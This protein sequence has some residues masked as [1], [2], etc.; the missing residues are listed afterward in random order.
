[1]KYLL[2]ENHELKTYNDFIKKDPLLMNHLSSYKYDI[3]Y[4][5]TRLNIRSIRDESTSVFNDIF[6]RDQ[7]KYDLFS[8][9]T[10]QQ[11]HF[12]IIS[13]INNKLKNHDEIIKN[14]E[15]ILLIYKGGNV[16][17]YYIN[18]KIAELHENLIKGIKNDMKFNKTS[19][20]DYTIYIVNDSEKKFNLIYYYVGEL[21]YNSLK[22]ISNFFNNLLNN[23]LIDNENENITNKNNNLFNKDNYYLIENNSDLGIQFIHDIYS[24]ISELLENSNITSLEDYISIFTSG[25]KILLFNN[26]YTGTRYIKVLQLLKYYNNKIDNLR[27][28]NSDFFDSIDK[29]INNQNKL[30]QD[31][32]NKLLFR[33][34]DFYRKDKLQELINKITTSMNSKES[35]FGKKLYDYKNC[36]RPINYYKI[37]NEYDYYNISQKNNNKNNIITLNPR[38]NTLLKNFN[39]I[40][41]NKLIM[42]SPKENIPNYHY[43]SINS[44]INNYI[45][46]SHIVNFDLFRIKLNLKLPNISYLNE[47]NNYEYNSDSINNNNIETYKEDEK[48]KKI[49][50]PTLKR[51][52]S[53]VVNQKKESTCYAHV[54]CRCIVKLII[55]YLKEK[56]ESNI[57][58]NEQIYFES[59]K[60]FNRKIKNINK[61]ENI[62]KYN[63]NILYYYI[64][65]LIKKKNGCISRG[66]HEDKELEYLINYIMKK[67]YKKSENL[68]I[69]HDQKIIK[70]INNIFDLFREKIID[71]KI[72]FNIKNIKYENILP[73]EIKKTLND[74]LY[75]C[76]CF[77]G[78]DNFWKK[79]KSY[80]GEDNYDFGT[81]NSSKISEIGHTVNIISYN[82]DGSFIIKNSWGKNWGNKGLMKII[83]NIFYNSMF[84]YID[85]ES[86]EFNI[87]SEFIDVSIPKY[88]DYN[89]LSFK[90]KIYDKNNYLT[91]L[92]NSNGSILSYNIEYLIEDLNIMLFKQNTFIP[93]IDKKYEKRLNKFVFV[94]MYYFINKIKANETL[95]DS[96]KNYFIYVFIK[97]I[98]DLRDNVKKYLKQINNNNSNSNLSKLSNS[99]ESLYIANKNSKSK[100]SMISNIKKIINKF[101]KNNSLLEKEVI[102][103]LNLNADKYFNND[104]IFKDSDIDYS[105]IFGSKL[106]ILLDFMFKIIIFH[107]SDKNMYEKYVSTKLENYSYIFESENKKKEYINNKFL[108][109]YVEFISLFIEKCELWSNLLFT[110]INN[111]KKYNNNDY[112]ILNN[113]EEEFKL[114]LNLDKYKNI[115]C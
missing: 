7:T 91:L 14:D 58:Y 96:F 28:I 89:L 77:Y 42:Y 90:E 88:N 87:P 57:D 78:D 72:K 18:K 65:K 37:E 104:F 8:Y 99:F 24:T 10:F 101:I 95:L 70:D 41:F 30:C 11:I 74:G 40:N 26:I 2:K 12:D 98:K 66:G 85:I 43:I 67:E 110:E 76:L 109:K 39:N 80:K 17:N 103:N 23:I 31:N 29:T 84:T 6:Y 19:D 113:P 59:E 38:D 97:N 46:N 45:Y 83:K 15:Y 60:N 75:C 27:E 9:Y 100:N 107:I 68:D 3:L 5:E 52:N 86:N 61:Q 47:K 33:L 92:K 36:V 16:L 69:I 20:V 48:N 82:E 106:N 114:N 1:M 22:K 51:Q 63:Y 81:I 13:Q 54:T 55:K 105:K 44:T 34:K 64:L 108:E 93:W 94:L 71:K 21:L 111:K 25:S 79:I 62:K 102:E 50:R 53:G 112:N 32:L 73:E 115:T 4:N 56:F 35:F 49:L